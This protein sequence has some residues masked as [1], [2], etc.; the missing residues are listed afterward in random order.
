MQG[1]YCSYRIE[2][3]TTCIMCLS[4]RIRRPS[5][6]SLL[7]LV[8][9]LYY[10]CLA[11]GLEL[12][13][14]MGQLIDP[15]PFSHSLT[16]PPF[17]VHLI[18]QSNLSQDAYIH[19]FNANILFF[20]FTFTITFFVKRIQRRYRVAGKCLPKCKQISSNLIVLSFMYFQYKK[21]NTRAGR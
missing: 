13:Y 20:Q 5:S 1:N 19:I 16:P 21:Y 11:F 17:F 9:L 14:G 15:F 12:W 7:L 6:L 2:S 8:L 10:P 18:E 3:Q 4:V